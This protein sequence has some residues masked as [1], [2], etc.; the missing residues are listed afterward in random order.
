MSFKV[1]YPWLGNFW[2]WD[3]RNETDVL[4]AECAVVR[5]LGGQWKSSSSSSFDPENVIMIG[6]DDIWLSLDLQTDE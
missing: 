1:G 5:V 2:C 3:D 4:F 6:F